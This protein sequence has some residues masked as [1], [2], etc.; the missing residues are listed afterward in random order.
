MRKWFLLLGLILI[1]Y[2]LSLV[3]SKKAKNK[4]PFLKRFN[5]TI[6]IL[7]WALT[8]AYGITFFLWLYRTIF[9]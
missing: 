6:T 2:L 5:E 9:K 7:V 1:V 4:S 3:N 8:A